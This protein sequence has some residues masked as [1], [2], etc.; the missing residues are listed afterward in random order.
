MPEITEYVKRVVSVKTSDYGTLH[1]MLLS[2][3]E[4]DEHRSAVLDEVEQKF[5]DMKAEL[6]GLELIA[7]EAMWSLRSGLFEDIDRE[8]FDPTF[9][10]QAV[11]DRAIITRGYAD[12]IQSHLSAVNNSI[13]EILGRPASINIMPSTE[14]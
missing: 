14:Q 4:V 9:D 6:M 11:C 2:D 12:K 3:K 1:H 10:R 7:T 8:K 5:K 13:A